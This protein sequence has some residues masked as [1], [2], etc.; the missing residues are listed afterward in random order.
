MQRN[1]A[2]CRWSFGSIDPATAGERTVF[3]QT[4]CNVP[5]GEGPKGMWEFAPR[6]QV[7]ARS[8]P[9]ME[10]PKFIHIAFEDM[11]AAGPQCAQSFP[12]GRR[13]SL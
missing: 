4:M 10:F 5:M 7:G 1:S 12:P 3:R 2:R 6:Y 8:Y 9:G 13:N 11:N